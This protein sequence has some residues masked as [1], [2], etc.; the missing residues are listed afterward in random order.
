M[1]ALAQ[2]FPTLRDAVGVDPWD[3]DR[4]L[5]WFCGRFR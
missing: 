1:T 2:S 4:F 3:A 5:G